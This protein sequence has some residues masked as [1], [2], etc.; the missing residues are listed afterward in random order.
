MSQ[1]FRHTV[2]TYKFY[3]FEGILDLF[4]KHGQTRMDIWDIQ[5]EMVVNAWYPVCYFHLSFGNSESLYEAILKLQA[6]YNIPINIPAADLRFWLNKHKAEIYSRLQFLQFNV[7]YRFLSPWIHTADNQELTLRSLTFENGCPYRILKD[8]S[9]FTIELNPEWLPYFSDNYCVLKNFIYWDLVMFLQPRNPNVPNIPGKLIRPDTRNSLKRQHDFWDFVM[10]CG[11]HIHC[12]YTGAPLE[13]GNYDLDH[14]IPWS[15]VTHDLIWN[16]LPAD[17]SINS[18]KSDK[19]PD[20][21]HYLPQLAL[22]QQKAI[23]TC[24]QHNYSGKLLEDYLSFGYS[25]QDL[26]DMPQTELVNCFSKV[27]TP[28]NQIALNMGFQSWNY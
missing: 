26:A 13:A 22:N 28:L 9:S 3:W 17:S 23:Q 14:F 21:N 15:F 6:D 2:A 12:I 19:L 8:A 7:P 25:I 18:S 4:V 1:V 27:F 16:L 11:E 24:L 10:N 5:V 20:L